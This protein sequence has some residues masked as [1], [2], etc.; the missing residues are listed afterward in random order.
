[1]LR[2]DRLDEFGK[3]LKHENKTEIQSNQVHTAQRYSVST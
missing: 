1:V 3:A 2:L